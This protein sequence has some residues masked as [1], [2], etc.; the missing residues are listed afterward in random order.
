MDFSPNMI[1]GETIAAINSVVETTVAE[2]ETETVTTDLTFGTPVFSGQRGQVQISVG[3]TG[4]L[5]KVTWIAS[6]SLGNIIEAEGYL[7]VENR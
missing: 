1:D 2:D 6:T 4:T 5:Y 7:M 3:L